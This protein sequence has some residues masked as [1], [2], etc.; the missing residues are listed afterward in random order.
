MN[1]D[2][3]RKWRRGALALAIP[4]TFLF[5]GAL[6]CVGVATSRALWHNRAPGVVTALI[7]AA[8]VGSRRTIEYSVGA[9]TY[10][11]QT[12]SR[13]SDD[14]FPIGRSVTVLYPPDH[15][16]LGMLSSFREQWQFPLFLSI[17][18]LVLLGLTWKS[19]TGLPPILHGLCTLWV[20]ILG[21]L[22]GASVFLL[23]CAWELEIFAE[24]PILVKSLGAALIFF[25]SVPLGAYGGLVLWQRH[26]PARCPC[27]SGAMRLEFMCKQ[28]IYTCRSCRYQ[29]WFPASVWTRGKTTPK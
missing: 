28:L 5:L 7:D 13:Y 19:K 14:A 9:K 26:V 22:L 4:A 29:P 1:A 15:P 6:N 12:E 17:F 11:I 3:A 16:Q 2:L 27:C 23:L 18:S 20:L 21:A 24:A 8:Q 10:Q 25:C